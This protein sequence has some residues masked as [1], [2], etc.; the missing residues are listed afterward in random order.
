MGLPLG[1]ICSHPLSSGA[2][3]VDYMV[4]WWRPPLLYLLIILRW[5]QW[6]LFPWECSVA[7]NVLSWRNDKFS[8][9]PRGLDLSRNEYEDFTN[10]NYISSNYLFTDREN[11]EQMNLRTLLTHCELVWSQNFI[12]YLPAY[13][14]SLTQAV[15][16]LY[17]S[18]FPVSNSLGIIGVFILSHSMNI[19]LNS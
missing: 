11:D 10:Y 15:M 12:Y 6:L 18:W 9:L 5:H 1:K 19:W 16:V 8:E 14:P 3:L 13:I 2:K 17:G 4:I 7:C